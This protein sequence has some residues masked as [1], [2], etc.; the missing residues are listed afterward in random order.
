M[1]A[2][3][4]TSCFLLDKMLTEPRELCIVVLGL[5]GKGSDLI[6]AWRA[7]GSIRKTV[8]YEPSYH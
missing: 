8:T 3:D 7:E 1:H 6:A 2:G 5:N 4:W